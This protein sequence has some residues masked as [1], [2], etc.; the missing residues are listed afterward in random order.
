VVPGALGEAHITRRQCLALWAGARAWLGYHKHVLGGWGP[1]LRCLEPSRTAAAAAAAAVAASCGC[2][3][4]ALR[5]FFAARSSLI[6]RSRCFVQLYV[7][8]YA[9][10]DM[11]PTRHHAC[12]G[13]S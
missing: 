2:A 10:G 4:W 1:A 7:K 5:Q 13:E 8:Q 3:F 6:S 11:Q 9:N 12:I